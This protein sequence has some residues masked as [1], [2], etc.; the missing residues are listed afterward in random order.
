MNYIICDDDAVFA[1][2]LAKKIRNFEPDCDIKIFNSAS[3]LLFNME[4]IGLDTD[5]VFMDIKLND[6]NGINVAV[7]LINKFPSLKI[8]YVTGYGSR[9][10]QAIFECPQ[11]FEPVAYLIKPVKEHYLNNALSKLR[12]SEKRYDNITVKTGGE[13]I[14]IR[15]GDLI[16]VSCSGRKLTLHTE[17]SDYEINGRLSLFFKDLPDCF[18]Q[19]SKSH[20]INITHIVR[21]SDWK[22]I[23]MS[24]G[25][26]YPLTRTYIPELKQLLLAKNSD[27]RKVR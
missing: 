11:G 26:E 17:K 20:I 10:S 16:G 15:P 5:A 21:I 22:K 19:I 7:R 25:S 27:L 9:Y 23:K 13:L 2:N 18:V 8:V 24:D 14:I 4:D 6:G 12:I 1:E 3:A